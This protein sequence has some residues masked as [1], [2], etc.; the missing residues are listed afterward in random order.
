M[1][2]FKV[3]TAMK[4]VYNKKGIMKPVMVRYIHIPNEIWYEN[5]TQTDWSDFKNC[6]ENL[7]ENEIKESD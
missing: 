6:D 4:H 7:I 1:E 5:T 2:L 3:A